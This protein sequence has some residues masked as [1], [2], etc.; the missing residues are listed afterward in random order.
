MIETSKLT[1][2]SQTVIPASIRKRLGLEPGDTVLYE[3]TEH[4]VVIRKLVMV[5]EEDP[6]F[7]PFHAFTEWSSPEDEE[8]FKHLGSELA[9][10]TLV[11]MP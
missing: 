11:S 10:G 4:G 6:T 7:D 8:A 2:K 3:V 5:D 9:P 1:T